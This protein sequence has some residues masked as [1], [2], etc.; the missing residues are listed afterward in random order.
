MEKIDVI[1]NIAKRT[2]GDIYLGVVGAVRTGKSTFIK[3]VIETL[4]VPNIED[5]YERELQALK[6]A[7]RDELDAAQGNLELIASINKKYNRLEMDMLKKH[8]EDKLKELEESEWD[9]TDILRRI[10][11]NRL[12]AEEESLDKHLQEI[13]NERNDAIE[14]AYKEAEEAA[15][16]EE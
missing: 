11:D 2:G 16:E 5:E 4:V 14:D 12:S 15:K 3:R 1:K 13:E 8:Q 9:I 10:R 7:K 6:N